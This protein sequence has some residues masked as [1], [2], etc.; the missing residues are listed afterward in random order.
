M[1]EEFKRELEA[2]ERAGAPFVNG[3]L[4]LLSLLIR[5]KGIQGQHSAF[6]MAI[7]MVPPAPTVKENTHQRIAKQ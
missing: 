7:P 6:L 4:C 3:N 5:T 2:R 1:V